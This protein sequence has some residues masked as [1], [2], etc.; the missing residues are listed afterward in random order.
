MGPYPTG[1]DGGQW[2]ALGRGLLGGPGRSTDGVYAPLAPL[3][4]ALANAAFGPVLGLKLVAM[5]SYAAVLVAIAALAR[6]GLGWPATIVALIVIGS[7]SAVVEPVAYGG[8]PQT[9]AFA[10]MLVG[11]G[12]LSASLAGRARS[13]VWAAL[14]FAVAAAS[15]HIYGALAV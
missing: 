8:Y 14:A 4:A 7:A 12:A 13:A 2:L 6:L 1:L 5:L 9:L 15:H 11:C 3:L 10:A